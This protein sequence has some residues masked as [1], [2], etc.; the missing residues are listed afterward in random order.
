MTVQE[1]YRRFNKDI[2]MAVSEALIEDSVEKDLTTKLISG[3]SDVKRQLTAELVCKQECILCGLEIFKAVFKELDKGATFKVF[4][5]DGEKVRNLETVLLVKSTIASLL[6]AER[7]ALNFIQRMS[8]IATLTNEFVKRLKYPHAKILHTRKTTPNFRLFEIMAVKTGGGDFHRLALDSSVMIKD[9]HISIAGGI[10]NILSYLKQNKDLCK[11]C[12][13]E[14][15][16]L[17]EVRHIADEGR[18]IVDTV[19][20]DNFNPSELDKAVKMLKG[21]NIE[22]SGGINLENFEK[23]QHDQV[24]YYSIGM[25]T[26]S[27]KSIDFSL[28]F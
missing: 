22:V 5:K 6:K 23:Y 21:F 25:L 2:R 10:G 4:K 28:E 17:D 19:M 20:L 3:L 18:G 15:K 26:H 12:E 11:K 24:D 13:I 16:S 9:N 7:T 27:Y 8:G 1:F 14:V